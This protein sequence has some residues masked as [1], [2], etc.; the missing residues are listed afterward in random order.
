M[1][2]AVS[3]LIFFLVY[4]LET[5]FVTS[6]PTIF[7][8]TPVVFALGVYTLQHQG[9][10]DGLIW[11]IAYGFLLQVLQAS[12]APWPLLTWTAGSLVSFVSARQLFSN[13]SLYGVVGCAALGYLTVVAVEAV[14]LFIGSLRASYDVFEG[15]V[16]LHS[17]KMGLL[18]LTVFILFRLAKPIRAFFA[19]IPSS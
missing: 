15:F 5:A 16:I 7:S 3:A 11:I 1:R 8:L 12:A 14:A 19:R 17:W 13:R 4:I 9:L 10:L 2:M 18:I 6:M